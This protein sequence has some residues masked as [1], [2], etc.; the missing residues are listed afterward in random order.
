MNTKRLLFWLGFII[1]LGLIIWGLIA[2]MNKSVNSP[3]TTGNYG[4]P[5]PIVATDHVRGPVNAPVTIIEYADFEC[6]ACEA[7]EP[8]LEKLEAEASTTF[9]I[10]YRHYPLPQHANALPAAYAAEAAGL[11]G[12]FWEMH[13]LLLINHTDWTEASDPTSIF[14]G[15][16]TKI[17]LDLNK[18]KTDMAGD[19]VK[20]RVQ[21]D[22]DESQKLGLDYTPT[23]FLNG[24]VISN[25]QG[26]EQFLSV[27]QAA[28]SSTAQ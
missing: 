17:G 7:Y 13:D 27:I 26:Y 25:P 18:F 4:T 15:Y 2:A 6:P 20:A 21:T 12:K 1:V 23:F 24:K 28:A 8:V 9:K 3:A 19:A 10:L 16:A 14:V 22:A 5:S 11:Q